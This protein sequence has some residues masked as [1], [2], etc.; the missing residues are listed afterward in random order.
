MKE[1]IITVC[2]GGSLG[3]W[4]L[5]YITKANYVIGADRGAQFLV[6][7]GFSPDLAIGDFDSVSSEQA[8]AIRHASK[9]WLGF[10]AIDKDYTDTQ[11]AI[12][13]AL[14]LQPAQIFL[15]GALGSR[16][17]HALANIQLL[18][19]A[20]EQKISMSII[21]QHN[22]I[23]LM[24]QKLTIEEHG[25]RYVSLLPYSEMVTGITL[26]GFKYPLNLAT[27]TKGRSIGI[28]NELQNDKGTITIHSGKL[29]VIQS[30][31]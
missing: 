31:D 7:Q 10:D 14:E 23:Q 26:Q 13:H 6:E 21:D 8:E 24:E 30:N 15:I 19:V 29:L 3:G 20:L 16:Y 11:L 2:S 18:E 9:Q 22:M 17:D 12:M 27:L 4:A 5:P 28:S 1:P 25:F